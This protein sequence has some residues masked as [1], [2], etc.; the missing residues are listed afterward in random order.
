MTTNTA[1]FPM[2]HGVENIYAYDLTRLYSEVIVLFLLSTGSHSVCTGLHIRRKTT[3][4]RSFNVTCR[5]LC[6]C[7][8]KKFVM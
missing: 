8:K 6:I 7:T 3:I 1:I 4:N 2:W 5:F